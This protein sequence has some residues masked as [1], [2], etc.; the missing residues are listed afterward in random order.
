MIPKGKRQVPWERSIATWNS[1]A[2]SSSQCTE[3][4]ACGHAKLLQNITNATRALRINAFS[5]NGAF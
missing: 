3:S 1:A 5:S 2:V 4:V